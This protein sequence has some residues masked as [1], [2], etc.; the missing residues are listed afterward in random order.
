MTLPNLIGCGAGKSGTTSL[1]YYLSQHPQI[2]M[3]A[4]KELHFF[5]RHYSEGLSWYE[6]FFNGS[7]NLPVIGEFSTSYMLDK[8]VPERIASL[9]PNAKLLFILRNPIERAYSNYWFSISIGT[10]DRSQS[11][12]DAIRTKSGFNRYVYSGYYYQHLTRFIHHLSSSQIYVIITEEFKLDPIRQMSM[13]YDFLNVDKTFQPNVE[14]Q[15]NVTLTTRNYL[16]G[17]IFASWVNRKQQIKPLLKRFPIGLRRNF[18]LLEKRFM[19]KLMTNE[20]P[21]MSDTDFALLRDEFSEQNQKLAEFIGREL[22][23]WH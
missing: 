2:F 6:S 22:S 1:Y 21:S 13:C 16:L 11:F 4:A 19:N 9:I 23:C 10:Q 5:S 14:Q 18:A 15:Y 3:A 7:E 20:R 12:S 17:K 8:A